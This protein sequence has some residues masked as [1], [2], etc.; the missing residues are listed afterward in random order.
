MVGLF[1]K[2]FGKKEEVVEERVSRPEPRIEQAPVEEA[3]QRWLEAKRW[4]EDKAMEEPLIKRSE[5]KTKY[6]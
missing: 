2:V 3:G 6:R 4:R 5:Y 1:G